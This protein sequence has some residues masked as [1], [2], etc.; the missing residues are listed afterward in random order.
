MALVHEHGAAMRR[1]VI[2]AAPVASADGLDV[3]R[4]VELGEALE[5]PGV[6]PGG[7]G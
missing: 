5:T 6:T 1:P 7:R 3:H 4:V 2:R